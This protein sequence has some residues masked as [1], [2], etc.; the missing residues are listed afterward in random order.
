MDILVTGGAGFIGSHLVEFY[1]KNGDNVTIL[2]SLSTGNLKNLEEANFSGRVVQGDIRDQKLVE[3]LIEE[4]DRVVHL[5]AALGVSNIMNNTLE[6]ISTNI[7]GSEVVL[8]TAAKY[9]KEIVIASTSEIY[10][11]NERQPLR[12]D[13]DRVLGHP[14]NFRW[15]YSDAKAIEEAIARVLYLENNLPVITIRFFNTVGPRQSSQYGMVL[16][17]FV[18]NA[19]KNQPI[20]V[21][22]DGL[23][24]RVFC[25]VY[26]AILAVDVLS[27][28]TLSY[29]EAF[30]V[31]GAEEISIKDLAELVLAVTN[32]KSQ[33]SY[34]NTNMIYPQGFEDIFRRVPDTSKIT[35]L[36]GWRPKFDL[37]KIIED[38]ASYFLKTHNALD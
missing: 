22:G 3:N 25:H 27:K 23:Q 20:P 33:I 8:K 32:S 34:V 24:S 30:N 31:G 15:S 5:A 17:N 1:E 10:G 2:D 16:P 6:S 11:K 18:K 36:T 19:L 26:D 29:G 38:V 13:S 37:T 4:S 7:Q 9:G 12:E 28:N 21:Y 14:Q 35:N